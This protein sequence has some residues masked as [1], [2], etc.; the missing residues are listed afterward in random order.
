VDLV[1]KKISREM[2][3]LNLILISKQGAKWL[4]G[5]KDLNLRLWLED[6]LV[7][8]KD[9]LLE[10]ELLQA[11]WVVFHMVFCQIVIFQ[12]EWA[13]PSQQAFYKIQNCIAMKKLLWE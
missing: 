7:R 11:I 6:D 2:L 3:I 8:L 4:L 5:L 13:E 9:L 10:L 1:A 12:Q